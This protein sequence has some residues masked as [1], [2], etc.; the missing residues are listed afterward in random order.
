MRSAPVFCYQG[1]LGLSQQHALV[2]AA[3]CGGLRRRRNGIALK[4]HSRGDPSSNEDRIVDELDARGPGLSV[5]PGQGPGGVQDSPEWESTSSTVLS[6]EGN[7]GEDVDPSP[8]ASDTYNKGMSWSSHSAADSTTHGKRAGQPAALVEGQQQWG[9]Q[10][11][12]Q[13]LQHPRRTQRRERVFV[14]DPVQGDLQAWD[15]GGR[16]VEGYAPRKQR[17]PR[18][19]GEEHQYTGSM[20]QDVDES[21]SISTARDADALLRAVQQLG[22]PLVEDDLGMGVAGALNRSDIGLGSM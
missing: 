20:L 16:Y 15:S 18:T 6:G 17:R 4:S 22:Q 1:G 10:Q 12:R 19:D 21:V 5:L 3:Q 11:Q 8:I 14:H 7:A 9:Q 13:W 2:L